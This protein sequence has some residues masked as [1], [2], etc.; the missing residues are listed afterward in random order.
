MFVG[1][2]EHST[3]AKSRRIDFFFF[4]H[5]HLPSDKCDVICDL[6]APAPIRYKWLRGQRGTVGKSICI[7]LSLLSAVDSAKYFSA[8][9]QA[10]SFL[11]GGKGRSVSSVRNASRMTNDAD[12]QR[13]NG[14][15]EKAD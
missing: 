7:H 4:L 1:G 2:K 5:R 12:G 6:S 8:G 11:L 10:L 14:R 13:L 15:R 9:L 3:T